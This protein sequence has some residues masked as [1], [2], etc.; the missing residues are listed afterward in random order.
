MDDRGFTLVE[1]L[2]VLAISAA[3]AMVALQ[4]IAEVP[5]RAREWEEASAERQALRTLETRLA[6]LAAGAAPIAVAVDDQTVSV[7]AI[8]PRRLGLVRPD[9]AGTVSGTAVTFLSRV[10]AHRVLILASALA[11][12]GGSAAFS[13][14]PGCGSS[15]ACGVRAGDLLLAVDR[16]GAA[17]LFRVAA[18][19]ARLD[20]ESLMGAGAASFPPGSA[21]VPIAIDVI[22]F[23]AAES[24]I[25]RYDGYRSDNVLIDGIGSAAIAIRAPARLDDG[26]FVGE[27]A[28]SFDTDQLRISAVAID[29]PKRARFEWRTRAWP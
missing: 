25:R 24:A 8:W 15:A 23:D 29:V 17:G 26:P 11:A 12:A 7:P 9:A 2:I 22:S 3:I 14:T 5:P 10:D 13:G 16:T 20:L 4:A 27:G 28:L 21:L 19:A 18:I 6:R 1:A